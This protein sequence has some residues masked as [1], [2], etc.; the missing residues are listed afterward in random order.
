MSVQKHLSVGS[1]QHLLHQ[2]NRAH[3]G[4]TFTIKE[5]RMTILMHVADEQKKKKPASGEHAEDGCFASHPELPQEMT[6]QKCFWEVPHTDK[7]TR[8]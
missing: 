4:T 8:V 2:N 7:R 1:D 6:L 5:G 3:A